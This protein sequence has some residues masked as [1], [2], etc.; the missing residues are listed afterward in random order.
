MPKM[1]QR[2]IKPT[3]P[4]NNRLSKIHSITLER[5]EGLQTLLDN[6]YALTANSSNALSKALKHRIMLHNV[7]KLLRE[8]KF[9]KAINETDKDNLQVLEGIFNIVNSQDAN[10]NT[11]IMK[12]IQNDDIETLDYLLNKITTKINIYNEKSPKNK[13]YLHNILD[14]RNKDNKTA[15]HIAASCNLKCYNL[16]LN[17]MELN[18]SDSS[19]FNFVTDAFNLPDR[20]KIKN[21]LSDTQAL[22]K[23]SFSL[24]VYFSKDNGPVMPSLETLKSDLISS[25][26]SKT[27]TSLN[28]L[29]SRANESNKSISRK[30]LKNALST[31]EL[32]EKLDN[33]DLNSPDIILSRFRVLTDKNALTDLSPVMQAAKNN[34]YKTL[35]LL[36]SEISSL[37]QAYT[38]A[39]NK[40]LYNY[41]NMVDNNYNTALSFA[42]KNRSVKCV[43]LLLKSGTSIGTDFEFTK[44]DSYIIQAI[45]ARNCD[46]LKLLI[47]HY[48]SINHDANSLRNYLSAT[49]A[50]SN[51]NEPIG[52]AIS[53]GDLACANLL[54]E[55]CNIAIPQQFKNSYDRLK[56]RRRDIAAKV[57]HNN[58]HNNTNIFSTILKNIVNS[59]ISLLHFL[60]IVQFREE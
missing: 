44:H 45:K 14:T 9:L 36:I 33:I 42:I 6:S 21:A 12:A 46:I 4:H 54:L 17:Y 11:P 56:V 27:K 59:I 16:I 2:N 43:N 34:D 52:I 41:L 13:V 3:I 25:D 37:Q 20:Q 47:E 38:K 28:K 55:R 30:Q 40:P 18:Y 1:M 7:K 8:N 31:K 60:G 10:G 39:C 29:F 26:I 58:H 48:K 19:K 53:N 57:N 24:A 35:S 49:T 51:Y 50:M 22:I 5:M 15:L 32:C 23:S